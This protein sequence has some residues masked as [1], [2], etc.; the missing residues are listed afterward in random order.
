MFIVSLPF[1]IC[2]DHFG[3]FHVEDC[4]VVSVPEK[5]PSL[6]QLESRCGV[7]LVQDVLHLSLHSCLHI[8]LQSKSYFRSC[9]DFFVHVIVT[10]CYSFPFLTLLGF[11][12]L[13]VQ[14]VF[15]F[16]PESHVITGYV[17]RISIV[18]KAFLFTNVSCVTHG[19]S[20]LESFRIICAAVSKSICSWGIMYW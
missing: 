12:L 8:I 15:H 10:A 16:I 19:N 20:S 4:S 3:F 7:E 1:F 18:K 11:P 17:S 14:D 5:F 13:H 9:F 6:H 2:R